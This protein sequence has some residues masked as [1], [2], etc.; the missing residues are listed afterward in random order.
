MAA[1]MMTVAIT[2]RARARSRC[3][4]GVCWGMLCQ[5]ALVFFQAR[6][7]SRGGMWRVEPTVARR[8]IVKPGI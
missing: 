4:G 5:F 1:M 3:R 2:Q 7:S 8:V 6:A